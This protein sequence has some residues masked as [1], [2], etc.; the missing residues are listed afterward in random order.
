[1][2]HERAR[3]EGP[4]Q[5]VESLGV[6]ARLAQQHHRHVEQVRLLR[7]PAADRVYADNEGQLGWTAEDL[8]RGVLLHVGA[9]RYAF[10]ADLAGVQE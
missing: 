6:R 9:L 5:L 8:S 10:F 2:R 4:Q 3:A 7:E 1:M